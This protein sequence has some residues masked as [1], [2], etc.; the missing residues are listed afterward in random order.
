[1][2]ILINTGILLVSFYVLF[3]VGKFV[4]DKIHREYNLVDELV[5]KDNPALA[6]SLAGYY[7]GLVI[8]IGGSIAGPSNGIIS[9]FLDI[10]L[11]GTLSIVLLN[12]SWFVCD[13][14]IL[15]KFRVSDELIRDQNQ[16]T[17]AVT[18]GVFIASGFLIYGSVTGEGGNI[19]TAA[20]FWA[21]G[22][23]MLILAGLIYNF[24]TPFD[25]HEEIEKDN[26]AAGVSFSGYLIGTGLI[27]GLSAEGDFY[28]WSYNAKL[29]IGYALLG[30]L[31]L[32]IVRILTDKV[33]LPT[34]KLSK[35]I[36][37]QEVP[38]VGAGYIEAF[39]YVAAAL[40]IN[41]CI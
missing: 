13:K 9:D 25:I 30:L 40:A 5:K 39:S 19:W 12:L 16:G 2:N 17:G 14:I 31:F 27:I 8:S 32:P 3:F 23:V 28:S 33:L 34:E 10:V 20:G 22:Q 6:L 11:Y 15:W 4:H 36:A 41:W 38:N 35:E 29:Y 21:I 18:L 7:L 1:M 24:I 26:V 37:G